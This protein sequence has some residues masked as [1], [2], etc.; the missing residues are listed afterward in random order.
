VRPSGPSAARNAPGRRGEQ[1]GAIP[2][3]AVRAYRGNIGVYF[4]G[5]GTVTP[6]NTVTVRSRVDGQLLNVHYREG[7]MVRQGDL[8]VEID[9]RPYQ[10]ALTQAQGTLARDQAALENARID[11]ARY[12]VLV[13][14][15]A[16]PEQQ[17]ATQQAIVR[18]DEGNVKFDEG[19]VAAAQTNLAYTKITAPI[20][21]RVGLRLV[22]PGNIVHASDTNGLLVITQMDPISV[23]FTI[24]EDQL[25]AVLARTR[26][27]QVLRVDAYSRDMTAKLAQ[28]TLTTVDNQ[29]DQT[30][31]TIRIR[32][33]FA[34]NNNGL[35]P[36]QF[37]NA[38]LLVQEKR[39]VVLLPNAAIQRTSDYQF[40]FLVQPNSTVTIRKVTL[41]TTEG[42]ITEITSGLDPDDVIVMTGVD[43]LQEGSRV[44][45][46]IS[47]E[48]PPPGNGE[49]AVGAG[50][51][52]A[53]K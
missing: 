17:L 49:T 43:K 39:G 31:G 18:Q 27:G 42:D 23:I 6:L 34:N 28:G 10:A 47:G 48:A 3:V 45:A 5:L 16:A 25:P 22:D 19:S 29:I 20:S 24:S 35:F 14:Q 21:G 44:E 38:R 51:K 1:G 32:S 11:L 46:Q 33:T 41:G 4:T 53:R 40:V 50:G 13:P 37:V 26:A 30:T 8:L 12:Q 9:P 52:G 15:R 2:V 7:D 36:N